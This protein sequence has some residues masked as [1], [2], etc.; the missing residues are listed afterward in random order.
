[1]GKVPLSSIWVRREWVKHN[2]KRKMGTSSHSLLR[3]EANVKSQHWEAH[4]QLLW[5]VSR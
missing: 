4:F 1:M 5:T 3:A 2:I